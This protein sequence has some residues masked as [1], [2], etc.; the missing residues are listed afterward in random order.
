M[1]LLFYTKFVSGL[2]RARQWSQIQ[3]YFFMPF[4]SN[5][6]IFITI[7]HY[8][9]LFNTVFTIFHFL[10]LLNNF[11]HYSTPFITIQCQFHY[12]AFPSTFE[13]LSALFSTIQQ[14]LLLFITKFTI[15]HFVALF[16]NFQ[17]ILCRPRLLTA[18]DSCCQKALQRFFWSIQGVEWTTKPSEGHRRWGFASN[19][20]FLNSKSH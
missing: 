14:Y 12:F 18:G 13:Q 2:N 19:P 8:S 9:T 20:F 15:L 4:L 6:A 1:R 5:S 17:L 11:Q 10:S 7:Q 16:Y 3:W